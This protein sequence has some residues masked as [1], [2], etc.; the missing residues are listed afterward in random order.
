MEEAASILDYLREEVSKLPL[1][2]M[3]LT[4]AVVPRFDDAEPIASDPG[5]L[6]NYQIVL[7]KPGT[8]PESISH[9]HS[10]G[11]GCFHRLG[12]LCTQ[13]FSD[14]MQI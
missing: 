9:V 2:M 7:G 8:S 5:T 6:A 10:N 3:R 11:N 1:M 4:S 12:P 13:P 14:V